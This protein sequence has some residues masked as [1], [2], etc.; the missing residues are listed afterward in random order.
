MALSS[1]V[2]A[3]CVR[4]NPVTWE[5]GVESCACLR[6]ELLGCT[7]R[8]FAED[9]CPPGYTGHGPYCYKAF[10]TA[11]TFAD[12]QATCAT[13]SKG[14][15]LVIIR[16][17]ATQQFVESL[18]PDPAQP[19]W[20]GLDDMTT[21]GRWVYSDGKPIGSMNRYLVPDLTNI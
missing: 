8:E 7:V 14:G 11:K 10:T 21:E 19:Y 9:D 6:F 12:A 13:D 15:K 1:A 4:I 2:T 18:R 3:R 5:G 16:D 17:T 20:I